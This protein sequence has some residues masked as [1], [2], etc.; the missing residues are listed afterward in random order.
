MKAYGA[1]E[2]EKLRSLCCRHR[3]KLSGGIAVRSQTPQERSMSNEEALDYVC[4]KRSPGVECAV[5]YIFR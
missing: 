1:K 2:G 3:A 5:K 4:R